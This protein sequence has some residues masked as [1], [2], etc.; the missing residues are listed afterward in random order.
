MAKTA[1]KMVKSTGR[2]KSKSEKVVF[3]IALGFF[4]LYAAFILFFF[5]FAF[6]V[7]LRKDGDAIDIERYFGGNLFSWPANAS[8]NSFIQSFDTL[9]SINMGKD[10]FL[11]IT[12]NSI[13]RTTTYVV[14]SILTSSMVCYILVFYRS[15][16][17][18]FIYNLGIFVAILPLYG[19]T[20]ATMRLYTDI[21]FINNPFA[22]IT[23]I[24][25]FGGY[26]F[27]MYSFYKSLSWD[28]AEA[29]FVDGASHYR[30]FFQ[31]MFP[32]ALPSIAALF[33][34]SFISAWNDYESTILY[35]TE[36]PNLA[37]AVY[38]L[39]V[40]LEYNNILP[41]YMAG[42]LVSLIPILIL[43]LTF[44]NSIMEKVHLGGLKG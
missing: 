17:T 12:W 31:I 6:L 34:M 36:Y 33:V 37:Y 18:K 30:V 35:M 21:G 26:F 44:Q 29:A 3:G 11:T 16:F 4:I 19:S 13:W 15:K 23:S 2:K 22:L 7:A 10:S 9:A 14:L 1:N 25:L 39:E 28:Y 38:A 27:Y 20:A 40:E 8:F 42:V 32:M 24:G 5:V 41:Q 43:F